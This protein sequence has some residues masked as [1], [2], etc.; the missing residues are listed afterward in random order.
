MQ[1][2]GWL[3][4]CVETKR[5]RVSN[6]LRPNGE[7]TESS[8]ETTNCLLDTLAPGSREVYYSKAA[9]EPNDNTAV[10]PTH[11]EIVSSIC[12]LE[13]MERAIN[14]FMPFKTPGPDCIYPVL[15]Q[16][17]WNSI[18]N[19]YQTI[20]QMCLKYSYVP[21]VWKKGTG[22]FIP[23]PGKE[24]YHKVKSFR[25][26]TFA[27]FQLK[28]LER[29]VLYHF[30]DDSNL[31][32]RFSAFQYGFRAGV[33]SETALHEF[34]RRIE[35]SLAKERAA[36][37]I[38]LDIVGAFD[39]ITHNGIADALR[40]LK[41]SSFLVHWIENLLRHRTVQVELNGEKIKRE[42]GKGNPQGGILSPF[43]W[44]CVL[45]SLLVDLRNRGFHVQAY[46]DDVAILVTGTNMLWIKGRAQKALNIASNWAHN[47]EL[48]FSS[49]K[50]EIVLFTN[51]RKPDFGT[52][53]LNGRQ[54]EI[55]KEA[56]LLGVTL[57]SKLTW[58]PHITRIARKA[59]A[60]LLQ[61]R[62]IVGRAW[63]LNPTGMRWI[64]TAMIRPIIT[65]ACTSWVGGVNK[66][67]LEKKLSR[68]QR[69][70]CLMISSA[71]PSTPTGAL[72][73]LLNITP[74]NEFILSEAVK[75]SYRLSRVSFWPAKTIGSTRKTK[76]HVD[77]CDEAKE[78]LP[79]L[80]MPAQVHVITKT[81]VFGKQYKCLVMERKD[82]VQYENALEPSIIRC[83]TDGSKLNGR[84]GASFY[85]EYASGSQTDQNFFHL[86]RYSTVFQV[87][88]F[89]IA[90]VAKK[91][92]MDRIVNEK[93]IILVES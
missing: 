84:A 79:L 29:L 22:I 33:S 70:A 42:V 75:G 53:R 80:S 43:L 68:V 54:L 82:A 6:I 86:G 37:G 1:P 8:V 73:M 27:S 78:N 62:Q 2:L 60:A 58:K 92:I 63:G 77:V 74:I 93:I 24:N 39:N 83:Y 5:F 47:Q 71:F 14:E 17:G 34:V 4:L 25:M 50:T 51:K 21:K 41:V 88:V 87:E 91:L 57:D 59:T 61:C 26:I 65:Y 10:L 38:F 48:Q 9:E 18:R 90:E 11:D 31:Q 52:L 64:Y 30:N 23:K 67:Y 85:I 89:A 55:S 19:I 32:A 76:S 49:K 28:W 44:N 66:K 81:K 7:F 46:A 20:F 12:S 69:L 16:K 3:K 13:K 36:L 35:L 40:E 45:N 15:L 72:K 56:T